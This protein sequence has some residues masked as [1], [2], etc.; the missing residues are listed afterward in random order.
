MV[1]KNIS[2]MY[3]GKEIKWNG[4]YYNSNHD[5]NLNRLQQLHKQGEINLY[6][7]IEAYHVE[8]HHDKKGNN[9]YPL[10]QKKVKKNLPCIAQQ[11]KDDVNRRRNNG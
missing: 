3:K 8:W 10:S 9:H 5:P 4:M 6:E 7:P 1:D 2:H 11:W